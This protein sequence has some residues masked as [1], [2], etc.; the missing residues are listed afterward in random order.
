[1][2]EILIIIGLIAYLGYKSSGFFGS[3][4]FL[5][6]IWIS[7]LKIIEVVNMFI[8]KITGNSI[9]TGFFKY[10]IVYF[11]VG[12]LFELFNIKKENLVNFG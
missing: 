11:L 3:L 4:Q 6:N 1:M 7:I 10:Y 2:L 9:L 8:I 5:Q 12:L